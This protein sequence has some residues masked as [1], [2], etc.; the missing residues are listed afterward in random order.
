MM[1]MYLMAV[2][3]HL[4]P[5]PIILLMSTSACLP[6]IVIVINAVIVFSVAVIVIVSVI[7]IRPYPVVDVLMQGNYLVETLER[8]KRC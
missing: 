2:L 5:F 8:V 6:T 7:V 4:P 1:T 3:L